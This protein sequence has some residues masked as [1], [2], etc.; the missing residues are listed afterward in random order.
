MTT[1]LLRR[2]RALTVAAVTLTAGTV[3]GVTAPSAHAVDQTVPCTASTTTNGTN[4]Q[5]AMSAVVGG[6][7]GT[8]TLDDYCVYELTV[9]ISGTTGL[10]PVSGGITVTVTTVSGLN[11]AT[12]ERSTA[13]ST[14]PFNIFTVTGANSVLNLSHLSLLNGSAP[15]SGGAV[16]VLATATLN[17]DH[18]LFAGN[19]AV[20]DGGALLLS[21]AGTGSTATITTS[22][23][24]DNQAGA[25]G[26]A[27]RLQGSSTLNL[28]DSS[29]SGNRAKGN[30]GGIE[31]NIFT[32]GTAVTTLDSVTMTHNTAVNG[33]AI[34]ME[35]NGPL[36]VTNSTISANRTIEGSGGG[37]YLANGRTNSFT[38]SHIDGNTATASD[39]NV[40]S[41]GGLFNSNFGAVTTLNTTTVANNQVVNANGQGGGIA[42]VAG[43]V[44]LNSATVTGNLVSGR[45]GKG[46][47]LYSDD[48][49]TPS[50]VNVNSSSVSSN[51][52]V[53]TGAV[54][55]GIY[56]SG[57][58]VALS[59][60]TVD[61][62]TAPLAPAPGGVYTTVAIVPTG[63][64][65]NG[66]FP[67]NCL[68]SPAMVT[69]CVN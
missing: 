30:G 3:L 7:G 53:G 55:G 37:V 39:D 8:I 51:K 52:V 27:I 42:G 44:T 29:V 6:G 2:A 60:A 47:G 48:T 17:A 35:G 25:S 11:T 28:S 45:F 61:N 62:N 36:T 16:R 10:T 57:A 9:P 38:G 32:T 1:H 34:A 33:G 21:N 24:S 63:G 4:L 69:G 65:I 67:T 46:G 64:S 66:N 20:N 22:T 56:N 49:D 26:G 54:S 31:G 5:T 40:A 13:G 58:T 18:M 50:V 59:S 14:T 23:F 41:G 19:R 15:D 12:I 43:T 68:L